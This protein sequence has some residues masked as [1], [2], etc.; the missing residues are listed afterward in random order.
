LGKHVFSFYVDKAHNHDEATAG[1]PAGGID[2][3]TVYAEII[4]QINWHVPDELQVLSDAGLEIVSPCP[5]T[6]HPVRI[7]HDLVAVYFAS[8]RP[9]STSKNSSMLLEPWKPRIV[10]Y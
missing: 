3:G 5:S 2:S 9:V 10:G 1:G 8:S 4:S 6:T 7:H